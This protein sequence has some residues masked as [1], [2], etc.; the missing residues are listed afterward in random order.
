MSST[1]YSLIGLGAGVAF[2]LA[3]KGLSHP[4]TARRGNLI[5]AFQM[6]V[7][8]SRWNTKDCF[9]RKAGTL[10]QRVTQGMQI[11]T[12]QRSRRDGI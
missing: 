11:N 7:S 2:I 8:G 10:L 12:M 9:Q 5:G 3:L 4:K 6:N 1:L